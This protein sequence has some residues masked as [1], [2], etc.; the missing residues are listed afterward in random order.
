M[1]VVKV[2]ERADFAVEGL[3]GAGGDAEGPLV[4]PHDVFGAR[5]IAE[6]DEACVSEIT[7]LTVDL[8]REA[9]EDF[10]EI[11]GNLGDAGGAEARLDC[12]ETS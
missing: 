11:V 7:E 4:G 1:H 3:P 8:G 12:P 10:D 6:A 2:G 9:I 5:L